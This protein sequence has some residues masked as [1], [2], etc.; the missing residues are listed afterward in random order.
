[1]WDF[2]G[3]KVVV[4]GGTKGIGRAIATAFATAGADVVLVASGGDPQDVAGTLRQETGAE[5]TALTC[6]VTDRAD[7]ARLRRG[8]DRLDV[9]INNAGVAEPTPID[10]SD[11]ACA[12]TFAR[13]LDVNLNGPFRVTH[14]LADRISEERGRVIFTGSILS[15][16]VAGGMSAYTAS[17][18]GLVGLA[19]SLAVELGPRGITVNTVLPG[20]TATEA[21]LKNLPGDLMRDLLA[22]MS[23]D[24]E[25][26]DPAHVAAPY[27]FLASPAAADIT[28]QSLAVDKGQLLG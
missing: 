6:D 14:A 2:T 3:H 28:G 20:T 12:E 18:H 16:R 15:R 26:L 4:T 11:G 21:N 25:P 24:P 1:M 7:V 22:Q 10:D 17:K 5:V 9:L 27:L 8:I 23:L 19:N 13:I